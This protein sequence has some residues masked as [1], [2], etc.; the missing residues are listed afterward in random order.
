M[1][2]QPELTPPDGG[3]A[4][5]LDAPPWLLPAL[6]G[7]QLPETVPE[8]RMLRGWLDSWSGAGHL[9]EAMHDLGYDGD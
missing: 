1:P 3:P 7:A 5:A 4:P 2:D 8:A 9:V 6:V